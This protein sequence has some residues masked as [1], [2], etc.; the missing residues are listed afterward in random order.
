MVFRLV[1]EN[2]EQNKLRGMKEKSNDLVKVSKAEK[3]FEEAK[4]KADDSYHNIMEEFDYQE[5]KRNTE[6]V[7]ALRKVIGSYRSYFMVGAQLM[8][9]LEKFIPTPA[10]CDTVPHRKPVLQKMAS[11]GKNITD[12]VAPKHVSVI[13]KMAPPPVKQNLYGVA[14]DKIMERE[15]ET[16]NIPN[17]IELMMQFVEKHALDVE[18]MLV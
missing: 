12:S 10:S 11:Q 5:E 13:Q 16:G 9:D 2:V 17:T 1:A 7:N 15:T 3:D 8:Q 4:R 14:L 18:G 6:Y